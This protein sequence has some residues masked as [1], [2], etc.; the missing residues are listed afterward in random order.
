MPIPKNNSML[1]RAK[2]LRRDMTPQE[3]KLWFLFLRKYP[4]KFYKQRIIGSYIVDFY[5]ASS[6]HIVELDG[7][8]HYTDQGKAYDEERSAFL[9]SCG[10]RILRFSNSQIDHGFASVCSAI[11]TAI[12][13]SRES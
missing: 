13:N 12:E 3:R 8:R 5:C 11:K 7:A 4:I 2:A 6:K 1:D 10:L 9:R